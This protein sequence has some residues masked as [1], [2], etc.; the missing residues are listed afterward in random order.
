MRPRTARR[1]SKGSGWPQPSQ[2]EL[3]SADAVP[4]SAPGCAEPAVPPCSSG[5]PRSQDAAGCQT[6]VEQLNELVHVGAADIHGRR[7]P[8]HIA[9]HAALANQQPVFAGRLQCQGG[10]G[11]GGRL[12]LAV[13]HQFDGLQQAH[14]AHVAD[15]FVL[16]LELFQAAPEVCARVTAIG[17]QVVIFNEID[18]SLRGGGS[19]W[20]A[21]E[22][23]NRQ[24][25][26]GIGYL[27]SGYRQTDRAA[28]GQA[29]GGC[30]DIGRHTPLLDAEPLTTGA[31]PTGLHFVT[32][33]Q[34]TVIAN[35]PLDDREV[36]LGRGDE[37]A[38]PLDG[39]GDK[40]GDAPAGSAA[41]QFFHV[42][43]ALHL[44]RG[45]G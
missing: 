11:G 3:R 13:L 38:N 8:K 36:F 19:Y 26:E 29:F 41:D 34:A 5:S 28:V 10:F 1:S 44:A 2:L 12:T 32:D 18:N 23:G 42:L 35:N 6:L 17:A 24:A 31:A 45:V 27:R 39:L 30:H 33:E 16:V 22:G 4:G 7:N 15:E 14:A 25:R 9:I 43:S 21:A 37:P 40:T 20:V